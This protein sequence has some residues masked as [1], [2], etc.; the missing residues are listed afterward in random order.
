V[1]TDGTIHNN[2]PD[3][4]NRDNEK[5]TRVLIVAGISEENNVIGKE[6]D[7]TLKYKDLTLVIER[8]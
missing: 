1:R 7:M 3:I 2:K 5:E 4:V 8:M 6:T